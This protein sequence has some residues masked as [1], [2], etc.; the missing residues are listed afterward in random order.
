MDW[1]L[2]NSPLKEGLLPRQQVV[3]L[4]LLFASF[5]VSAGPVTPGR[6]VSVL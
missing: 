4:V 3:S 5:V 1:D 6:D 2:T